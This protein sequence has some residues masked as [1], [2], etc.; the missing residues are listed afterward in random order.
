M[1]FKVVEV[2][3]INKGSLLAEVVGKYGDLE[4]VKGFTV[5]KNGKG[6]WVSWPSRPWDGKDG[7]R[8][9]EPLIKASNEQRK[10]VEPIILQAV[11]D[12]FREGWNQ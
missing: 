7:Q 5:F 11:A 2:R 4:E 10:T 6:A 3:V 9:W 12:K 8:H 1:N